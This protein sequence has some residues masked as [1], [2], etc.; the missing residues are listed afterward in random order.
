M[1]IAH[2]FARVLERVAAAAE[3][4]ERDGSDVTV[5]AVSKTFP[6][7]VETAAIEAGAVELV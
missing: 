5:V 7:D 1:T 2:R 4:S 6:A 3:R